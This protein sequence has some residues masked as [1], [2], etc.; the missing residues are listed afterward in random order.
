MPYVIF[1]S[2]VTLD[3]RTATKT[4]DSK[5][6]T[7]PDS[8]RLVHNLRAEVDAVMVG[9]GTVL[10]DD[11]SLTTHGVA[12]FNPLRII[13][14]STLRIPLRARILTDTLRER[15]VIATTESASTR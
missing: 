1:K 13:V 10:K 3:G 11:P 14:D 7:S 12:S 8:R 2:A 6:I 15:T 5:W 4:G 9:I